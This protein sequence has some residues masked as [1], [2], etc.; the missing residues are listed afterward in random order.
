M[1]VEPSP[2]CN[3]RKT[4]PSVSWQ[5]EQLTQLR[6]TAVGA[7]TQASYCKNL[8]RWFQWAAEFEIQ[9]S[10]GVSFGKCILMESPGN[11]RAGFCKLWFTV[12]SVRMDLFWAR[13][14]VPL[15]L[16]SKNISLYQ[17]HFGKQRG[18]EPFENL[19]KPAEPSTYREALQKVVKGTQANKRPS[20]TRWPTGCT[21]LVPR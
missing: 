10:D 12:D 8:P 1:P 3:N 21:L 16:S 14:A 7:G 4:L 18:C 19:A 5:G 13:W 2:S 20:N 11:S 17:G 15:I 6:I 9:H